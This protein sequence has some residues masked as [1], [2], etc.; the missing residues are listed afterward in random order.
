MNAW[1][2]ALVT[3]VLIGTY[4][5]AGRVRVPGIDTA[6]LDVL[7]ENRLSVLAVGIRPFAVACLYVE[8]VSF[9][10][11]TT[12]LRRGG[13]AGRRKLNRFAM[14]LGAAFSL[15]QGPG[16]AIAFQRQGLVPNPGLLFV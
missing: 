12:T 7:N 3:L 14:Y 13:L 1:I 15:L 6:G 4:L 8:L 9:V 5:L 10:F 2:R 11:R 16:I